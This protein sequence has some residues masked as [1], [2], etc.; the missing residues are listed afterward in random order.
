MP[1]KVDLTDAR[2]TFY[3]TRAGR[4]IEAGSAAKNAARME[5]PDNWIRIPNALAF[6]PERG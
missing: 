4:T 6:D 1:T 2:C 5:H 3:G